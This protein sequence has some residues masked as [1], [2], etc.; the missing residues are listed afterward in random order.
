MKLPKG[1]FKDLS[2]AKYRDQLKLLP[3]VQQENLRIVTTLILTFGAMSFFG[4]FAIN[5]TLSTIVTLQKQLADSEAVHE[6]LKTK[7]AALSSLQQQYTNLQEQLPVVYEAVPQS[8]DAPLLTAQIL[9]LAKQQNINIVSLN[10]A[11][12]T[13][14]ETGDIQTAT[15]TAS[16]QDQPDPQP[17]ASND[18]SFSFSLQA[19]GSYENLIAFAKSLSQLSRIITVES[20]AL[21]TTSERE[22]LTMGLEGKAYFLKP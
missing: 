11:A 2:L 16:P 4:I 19:Q 20:L 21:N 17:I 18:P 9:G 13:L 15:P 1:Y 14:K 3:S 10:T 8:P 7:I 22:G 5:P 12:M 6:E